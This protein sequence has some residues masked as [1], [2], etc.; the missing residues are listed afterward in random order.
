MASAELQS[1]AASDATVL[2]LDVYDVR[3]MRV[4][5]QVELQLVVHALTVV[6]V[7][8]GCEHL[9]PPVDELMAPYFRQIDAQR[10]A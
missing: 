1:P 8:Q 5:V 10:Y 9:P 6:Q 7:I 3:I 2:A 4:L